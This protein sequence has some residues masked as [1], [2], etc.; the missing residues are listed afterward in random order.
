MDDRPLP[1]TGIRVLDL[2]R[3]YQGPWCGALLALA[4]ATVVKVEEP[5]GEPARQGGG[6]GA[7]VPFAMLNSNKAGVTINLKTEEGRAV[8][9]DLVREA[10]VVLE[11]FGPGTMDRLGLGAD[12]LLAANPRLIYAAATGYGVDGPDRDQLAM[13]ITI[14]AHAGVMSV[15]GFPDQPPVKAGVAFADFLG[16]A[17]LYGG[18]VTALYERERTGAGRVVDVAMID[19][20]YPTL[21]SNLSAYY[22]D[23]AAP[24]TGNG[25][26]GGALVPY[27]VYP[28]SDGYLA[29]IV[30]T[31]QQWL[32]FCQAI[33]Q[34]ELATD[35]RFSSNG[36]RYRNLKALDQIVTAWSQSKTRAEAVEALRRAKVPAAAVRDVG[37]VVEDRHLHERGAIQHLDH[38]QLGPLVVPHSALRF[39][40]SAMLPLTP[41]PALGADTRAV[42]EDWLGLAPEDIDRLY[43]QGAL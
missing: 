37:E 18:I 17:H 28:T 30:I 10:D 25:H 20:M 41:S 23:G 14:Q 1:L 2:G 3:I 24:R 31:P 29:V 26:G 39:R 42:L 27:D 5:G 43:E 34:P 32:G 40:G 35:E 15:T 19:T 33:G 38:P 11:N 22:R 6:L 12:V 7:T 16:A 4:G 9:L 36:R 13:D 21:A 8:F